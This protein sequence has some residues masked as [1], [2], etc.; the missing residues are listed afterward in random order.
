MLFTVCSL[1][2]SNISSWSLHFDC[3]LCEN[4]REV[5][6]FDSSYIS[7]QLHVGKVYDRVQEMLV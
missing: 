6:F 5:F 3:G 2:N 4:C 7:V 1:K